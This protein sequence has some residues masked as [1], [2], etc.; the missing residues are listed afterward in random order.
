MFLLEHVLQLL[1]LQ[2]RYVSAALMETSF[3]IEH[4]KGIYH[5][6]KLREVQGE[7][8]TTHC[9]RNVDDIN[10]VSPEPIGNHGKRIKDGLYRSLYI[11][12]MYCVILHQFVQINVG[13]CTEIV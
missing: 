2:E 8:V 7:L 9:P 4:Y 5:A 6:T 12:Q 10:Y 13:I 11:Q 3:L 1:L